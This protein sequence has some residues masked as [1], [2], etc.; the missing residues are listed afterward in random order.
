[1]SNNPP[2]DATI[3]DEEILWRRI[4]P[5][6]GLHADWY[7]NEDGEWRPT[8]VAFLDNRSPTHSLSAYLASET[9]LGGLR[10]DYPDDNIAGFLAGTPRQFDHTIQRVPDEGYDSHLEITPPRDSWGM[11]KRQR[12]KRKSAARAMAQAAV[13]VY[14]NDPA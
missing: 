1:M 14:Y 4:L 7:K 9:D 6:V 11:E 3:G 5:R 2:D 12:N 13:W 8:S 10:N